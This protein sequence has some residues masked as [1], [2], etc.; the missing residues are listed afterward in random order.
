MQLYVI[1]QHSDG[2]VTSVT[3]VGSPDGTITGAR[4]DSIEAFQE[5]I[6]GAMIQF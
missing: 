3:S 2:D 4:T 6:M 5:V 1:Y